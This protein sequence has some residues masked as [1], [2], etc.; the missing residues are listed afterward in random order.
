[1]QSDYI[2]LLLCLFVVVGLG[3][4]AVAASQVYAGGTGLF[5]YWKCHCASGSGSVSPVF[6]LVSS[7]LLDCFFVFGFREN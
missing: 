2:E 6:V 5:P 3:S 4:D 1:M 7:G